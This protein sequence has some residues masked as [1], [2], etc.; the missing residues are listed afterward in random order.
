[1]SDERL[2]TDLFVRAHLWRLNRE[3]KTAVIV[4]R[5]PA[6]G[7]TV[8]VKVHMGLHLPEDSDVVHRRARVYV[9]A[10]DGEGRLIWMGAVGDAPAA[11][12]DVDSYIERN[13]RRDPDVWVVEVD[14]PSGENPF[15]VQE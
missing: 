6:D 2:Q 5:G 8:I 1:M 10:R 12:E 9:Q 7:A 4:R 3:G 15:E 13:V 14:D 11:E